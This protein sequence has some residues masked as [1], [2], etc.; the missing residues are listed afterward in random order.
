MPSIRWAS[1]MRSFARA[2]NSCDFEPPAVIPSS[3]GDL[4]VR[5]ALHVVEKEDRPRAGR[6]LGR[7]L[8]DRR[9]EERPLRFR[10]HRCAVVFHVHLHRGQPPRRSRS[11]FSVRFTA[12]RC[13]QVPNCASPRKLGNARK[14]WIHTSC[15]M[16][17]ARSGSCPTSRRTTTSICGAWRVQSARIADSSP[18]MARCTVSC[19]FS[20]TSGIGH[21][22]R[23]KGLPVEG[24]GAG[25]RLASDDLVR[26]PRAPSKREARPLHAA[27][28]L[29]VR[30][31]RGIH[32]R[33]LCVPCAVLEHW[34]HWRRNGTCGVT[35]LCPPARPSGH[36][37]SSIARRL[38]C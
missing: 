37:L 25:G 30:V 34:P 36:S 32:I 9:G 1:R 13:A 3:R 21:G 26:C 27:G 14:I 19:S 16:S 38:R 12:I 5:V 4:L 2:L 17:A 8:L 31:A 18:S 11:A 33:R 29:L 35:E 15:A 28:L 7:R 24:R 6:Q 22:A 23:G 10:F 20:M